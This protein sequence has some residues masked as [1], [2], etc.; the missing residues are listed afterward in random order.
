M[1]QELLY[2]TRLLITQYYNAI[3]ILI[4]MIQGQIFW[5][6]FQFS[7][8]SFLKL[9]FF[10]TFS[11][12][13]LI[14]ANFK[15]FPYFLFFHFFTPSRPPQGGVVF[16]NVYPCDDLMNSY[17]KIV[18]LGILLKSQLKKQLSSAWVVKETIFSVKCG[19]GDEVIKKTG[20]TLCVVQRNIDQHVPN[21]SYFL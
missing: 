18:F 16:K 20:L 2:T 7:P 15:L 17:T 5:P 8:T 21:F 12:F 6:K 3:L 14:N 10:Y 9:Y 19:P 11:V 13:P 1:T 4:T